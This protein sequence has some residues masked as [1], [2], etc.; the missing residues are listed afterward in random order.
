ME[1]SVIT[2]SSDMLSY[3]PDMH[4]PTHEFYFYPSSEEYGNGVQNGWECHPALF[5]QKDGDVP[6]GCYFT[7]LHPAPCYYGDVKPLHHPVDPIFDRHSVDISPQC[8]YYQR[9]P[10]AEYS[11]H[12]DDTRDQSPPLEVSETEEDHLENHA[13]RCQPEPRNNKKVRLYQ[14]LLNLLSSGDMKDSIWWVDREQGVFQFSSKHKDTLAYHW[15]I[16]KGNRK[17]MT[18]QKMARALR[19]YGKTGEIQKIKK[20]LTYQFSGEVLQRTFARRKHR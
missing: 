16:Q 10:A 17:T 3:D 6:N 2:S 14:F 1:S 4:H 8:F 11:S 18:Y 13:Q 5:Q 12:E 20:K 7:E 9:S 19:N 15:G